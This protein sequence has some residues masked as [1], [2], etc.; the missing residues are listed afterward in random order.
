MSSKIIKHNVAKYVVLVEDYGLD[1]M[2]DFDFFDDAND[3]FIEKI[4]EFPNQK[5]YIMEILQENE[6]KDYPINL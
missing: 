3:Y 6:V 2:K 5:W 1:Y 4:R